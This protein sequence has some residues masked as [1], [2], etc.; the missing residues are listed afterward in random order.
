[1][2]RSCTHSLFGAELGDGYRS[3]VWRN[4]R[5]Q[6]R[7][8]LGAATSRHTSSNHSSDRAGGGVGGA[9]LGIAFRLGLSLAEGPLLSNSPLS[10]AHKGG[11]WEGKNSVG[12][13]GYSKGRSSC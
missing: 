1:M 10:L 8:S 5:T 6:S 3:F 11:G 9:A 12:L 4:C 13:L 2:N 7:S